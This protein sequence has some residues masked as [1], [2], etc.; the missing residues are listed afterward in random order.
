VGAVNAAGFWDCEDV[1]WFRDGPSLAG[2]ARGTAA[3]LARR[4][5][6]DDHR[7]AEVA[8]AVTEAATN[9]QRHAE[10]GALLLRVLRQG[11]RVA[12]EF[13]TVDSGPGITDVRAALSDGTSTAGSLGIG[14]GAVA[15]LADTFDV[16]SIPGRGTVV[17]AQF[18]ARRADGRAGPAAGSGPLAVAGVTRPISGESSC[19]DAWAVRA[20]STGPSEPAALLVLMCDGLGHGP[21]AALASEA[22]VRAFHGTPASVPEEVIAAVHRALGGTRGAA[23]AVARVD[24]GAGRLTYCGIGNVS[25]F[26]IGHDARRALLSA[27]GI[28][29]AQ[30]RRLRTFE[31][32]L[33]T[34]G[35][36]VMHTD[37]L[38]ERWEPGLLPG[39]LHHSPSVMAGH[40]LREAG[41]RRDDAG[42]VV[43]K[44]A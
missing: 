34:G 3:A 29:G 19:G 39:L 40:L 42:V 28:V 37:G 23:V 22:A 31:E 26:L 11:D 7:A 13:L 27:P 17:A 6:L 41:V 36:L 12:V 32:P 44:Y 5:G 18:W 35:A 20:L 25:G 10:D 9:I 30:M 24:V 2:A 38:T 16:H 8:L 21:L 4:I 15:R 33:P 43:V 1:A 14:L